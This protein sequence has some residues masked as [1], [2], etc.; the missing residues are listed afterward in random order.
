[1]KY[2]KDDEVQTAPAVPAAPAVL[3]A[4]AVLAALDGLTPEARRAELTRYVA[5]RTTA[6]VEELAER[7]QV[8]AMTVHRDL[9]VLARAGLVERIRGGARAIPRH[10]SERDVRLRTGTRSAQKEALALAASALARDGDIV[11]FDDSTTVAAMCPHIAVRRPSAVITHSLGVMHR[12]SRDHPDITLVGLGGQYYPETDS[13]LGAVVVDQITRV[14]ADVAFLSTTSLRNNALYHPDAE[15]ALTKRALV[16]MAE[17]KVL[18]VDSSKFEVKNGLYLVVDL[19][20][21]DDVVV[22]ATLPAEHRAQ[23][24]R[25]DLTVHYVPAT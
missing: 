10:L 3:P 14:F 22:E 17:R 15:A 18:L 12:L 20:A 1:M 5:E 8:S 21:F 6:K 2:E 13:F 25:L 11:A 9:D 4:P 7:F 19:A 16:M 23:L 24:E